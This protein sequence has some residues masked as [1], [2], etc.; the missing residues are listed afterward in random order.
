MGTPFVRRPSSSTTA[1]IAGKGNAL[2]SSSF[3]GCRSRVVVVRRPP[4][5]GK[6]GCAVVW[7]AGGRGEGINGGNG[8]GLG[9]QR[10]HLHQGAC[11]CRR[12]LCVDMLLSPH[13]SKAGA[14]RIL[15][16]EAQGTDR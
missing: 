4:H 10:T 8:K 6:P 1:L 9:R 5:H 12:C 3:R 7:F 15:V 16:K 2:C 14:L 11:V 13:K